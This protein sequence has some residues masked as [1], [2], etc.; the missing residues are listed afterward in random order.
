MP[1]MVNSIITIELSD[2]GNISQKQNRWEIFRDLR[3]SLDTCADKPEDCHVFSI[4]RPIPILEEC[5]IGWRV[6]NWGTK[7][8]PEVHH[9]EFDKNYKSVSMAISTAWCPPIDLLKYLSEMGFEIASTFASVEN[10][11]F[12][13]YENGD[14]NGYHIDY[15]NENDFEEMHDI[16]KDLDEVEGLHRMITIGLGT[17][18][19]FVVD[20]FYSVYERM[21]E[22]YQEWANNQGHAVLDRKSEN[23]RMKNKIMEWLEDDLQNNNMQENNYL[24]ICN[25]LKDSQYEETKRGCDRLLDR[26]FAM[27]NYYNGK[28]EPNLPLIYA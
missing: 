17:D 13:F 18:D 8:E 20:E 14:L 5:N 19:E 4:L 6:N 25:G 21:Y 26:K 10:E 12:G 28:A 2:R 9:Y 22:E 27:I 16:L 7:W 3:H 24:K 1:N 23:L 11:N 15:F